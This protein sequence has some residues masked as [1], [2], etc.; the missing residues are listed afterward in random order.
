MWTVAK[1]KK[2]EL[3]IFKEQMIEKFG[4]EIIF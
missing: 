4:Q 1:F 2:K 3:K